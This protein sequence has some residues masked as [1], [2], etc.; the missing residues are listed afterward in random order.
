M[1]KTEKLKVKS[2]DT[3]VDGEIVTVK[4]GNLYLCEDTINQLLAILEKGRDRFWYTKHNNLLKTLYLV[5]DTLVDLQPEEDLNKI[6]DRIVK[7]IE[8]AIGI[9]K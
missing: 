4:G 8:E 9:Q 1:I 7:V 6:K 5:R 2:K 3:N